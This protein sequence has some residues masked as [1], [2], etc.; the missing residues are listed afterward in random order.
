MNIFLDSHAL[1]FQY[2]CTFLTQVNVFFS[3]VL[4]LKK[5]NY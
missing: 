4:Q 3:S 1:L 5:V 2:F